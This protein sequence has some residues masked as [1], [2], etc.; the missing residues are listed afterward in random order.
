MKRL[1][2]ALGS[3]HAGFLYKSQVKQHLID[4]GYDVLDFGTDSEQRVDYPD[5]VKPAAEAVAH[6]DADV[7]IVFG[8]SGNG[9]AIVANKVKG[10]RCAVCWNE[11]SAALAKEHNDANIIAI[12]QRMI[13]SELALKIVDTWLNAS[14]TKGRHQIRIDKIRKM[15]D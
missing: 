9:E 12:G 1:T 14:F 8:G 11:K 5:F 7:G 4:R 15:E 10:T 6:G 3:D 2:I 13:S